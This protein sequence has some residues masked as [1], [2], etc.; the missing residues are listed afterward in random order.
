M[1][2]ATMVTASVGVAIALPIVTIYRAANRVPST[3]YERSE[4]VTFVQP[5]TRR[6]TPLAAPSL[7]QSTPASARMRP[8]ERVLNRDTSSLTSNSADAATSAAT[9]EPRSAAGVIGPITV[10]PA[11]SRTAGVTDK[12]Q[13][14]WAPLAPPLRFPTWRLPP[15][16]EER[17]ST[18]REQ[19]RHAAVARDE[20]RPMPVPM[21]GS[22]PL[23]FLSSGP[24][25]QQR[26]KDSVVN[27]DNLLRLAR[28][29]ERARAKRDSLLAATT[30]A[31]SA[32]SVMDAR[33]DSARLPK[34]EPRP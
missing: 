22:L 3:A 11:I 28:L 6:A 26:V 30:L 4:I 23:P 15:T 24:S 27:A 33:T 10:S 14:W 13:T 2:V 25:R 19:S 12:R 5:P 17:D 31:G 34:P 32:K 7:R 9:D 21:G 20:H 1:V 18:A 8:D 29:A 16:A